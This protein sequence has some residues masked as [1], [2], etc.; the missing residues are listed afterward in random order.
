M[1]SDICNK[2]LTINGK[3]NKQIHFIGIAR[4]TSSDIFQAN[5]SEIV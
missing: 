3:I 5:L 4:V 1:L 2:E